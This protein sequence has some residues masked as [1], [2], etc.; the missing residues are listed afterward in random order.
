MRMFGIPSK[1]HLPV[2]SLKIP[3]AKYKVFV[4]ITFALILVLFLV[5][6]CKKFWYFNN[7]LTF[8]Y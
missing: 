1:N 3:F 4:Y 2:S 6:K 8:I 5:Q 7:L